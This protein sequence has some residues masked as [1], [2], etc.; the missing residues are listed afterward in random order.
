[1]SCTV[2][3]LNVD[4]VDSLSASRLQAIADTERH[5]ASLQSGW[6]SVECPKSVELRSG[7][8][9]RDDSLQ[10]LHR[11]IIVSDTFIAEQDITD[12]FNVDTRPA[13]QPPQWSA[14]ALLLQTP[15]IITLAT[16]LRI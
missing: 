3:L 15:R 4:P 14:R 13:H 6:H 11:I 7:L 16:G 2:S 10:E 8:E 1:V 12:V 9:K 5:K